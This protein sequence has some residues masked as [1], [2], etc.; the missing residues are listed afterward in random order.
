MNKQF[1]LLEIPFKRTADCVFDALLHSY[2]EQVLQEDPSNYQKEIHSF[3]QCRQDARGAEKN[4]LGRD[5]LARYYGQIEYLVLRFPIGEEGIKCSFEW[6]LAFV[7]KPN[8]YL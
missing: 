3:Q 5:L 1:P 2:I 4:I 6:Y 8:L 7:L